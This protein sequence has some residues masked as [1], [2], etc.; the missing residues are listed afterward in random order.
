MKSIRT[1]T[2]TL[3]AAL[4]IAA[5]AVPAA[6]AT[7][8]VGLAKAKEAALKHAGVSENQTLFLVAEA[9]VEDGRKEYEV[10]FVVGEKEYVDSD[11]EWYSAEDDAGYGWKEVIGKQKA[12][13]IA[14]K[15]AGVSSKETQYLIAKPTWE[16]GERVYEVEFLADGIEYDYEI[17]AG[18]GKLSLIHI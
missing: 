17:H 13:E 12:I 5:M 11:L 1:M 10:E 2:R 15:H 9:D 14:L 4:L 6:A 7:K 16:D 18:S 8:D 3:T